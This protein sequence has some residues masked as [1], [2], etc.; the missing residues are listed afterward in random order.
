MVMKQCRW[1]AEVK[2]RTAF[3]RMSSAADGLQRHC[4]ECH[5]VYR[6]K[7]YQANL[8]KYKQLR[9]AWNRANPECGR[10]SRRRWGR[11]NPERLRELNEIRQQ[12]LASAPG[13]PYEPSRYIGRV[14]LYGDLCAYCLERPATTLDHAI[15]VSRGGSNWPANIYPACKPCNNTKYNRILHREWVPPRVRK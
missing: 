11:K 5:R 8:E 6:R 1:C 3:A 13:G 12:R 15:P 4:R 14:E 9:R 2:P 7:H 10:E